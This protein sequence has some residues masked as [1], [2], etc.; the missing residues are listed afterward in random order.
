MAIT[1]NRDEFAYYLVP[2]FRRASSH[3]IY[4]Y[5]I[6]NYNTGLANKMLNDPILIKESWTEYESL[7]A[8]MNDYPDEIHS[9]Q[10][11]GNVTQAFSYFD[12]DNKLIYVLL[13]NWR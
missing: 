13:N 12:E 5:I 10:D 4:D 6:E 8:V 2:N 3:I 7:E 11:I 1:V 9:D